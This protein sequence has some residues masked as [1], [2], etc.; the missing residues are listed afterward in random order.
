MDPKSDP[1]QSVVLS[2]IA[3][4]ARQLPLRRGPAVFATVVL[5]WARTAPVAAQDLEP[6]TFWKRID[7]KGLYERLWEASRLYENEDSS[8]LQALSIIGRYNGQSER[9]G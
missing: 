9:L 7:E 6:T 3:A 1:G 5:L 4:P 2:K 8:I